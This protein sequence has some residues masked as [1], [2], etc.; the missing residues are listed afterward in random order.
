MAEPEF[1]RASHLYKATDE[2]LQELSEHTEPSSYLK[3]G[4]YLQFPTS[5]HQKSGEIEWW[6]TFR[7]KIE[8]KESVFVSLLPTKN[9]LFSAEIL[10]VT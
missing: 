7:K 2:K 9:Q 1:L 3:D 5:R 4:K 6:K 10:R 8:E